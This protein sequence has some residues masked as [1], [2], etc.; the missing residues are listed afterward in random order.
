VLMD[1]SDGEAIAFLKH[2]C[3]EMNSGGKILVIDPMLPD[4]NA[5][6][7]N[8]LMDMHMLVV[9]GGA[10]RTESQFRSLFELVGLKV[11][12]VI[13]TNSPNFIIEGVL[14]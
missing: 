12:R 1:H 7:P 4:S 10:C 5:P 13:A 8:W 11:S 3:A 14:H 6:H 2:C 9:H